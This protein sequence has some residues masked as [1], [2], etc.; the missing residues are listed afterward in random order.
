MF[1]CQ[2]SSVFSWNF[3]V[4]A[5][6]RVIADV[7][8][9]FLT[10]QGTILHRGELLAVVKH[11]P[12]SGRWT[13]ERD[14]VVLAEAYKPSMFQRRFDVTASTGPLIVEA[15]SPFGR[16]FHVVAGT[17]QIVGDIHPAHGFSREAIVDCEPSVAERDQ[18][19]AFWL[20]AL[21]WRRAARSD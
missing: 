12:M 11:G 1:T 6:E 8:F 13:L 19:F 15:K 5:D 14:G 2:P 17:D 7:T 10:E 4:V 3:R 16:G 20:V 21:A 9:D 18:L